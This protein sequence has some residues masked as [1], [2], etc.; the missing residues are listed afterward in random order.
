MQY[1]PKL[2]K[3][4]AQIKTILDE[5]DIAGSVVLHTPGFAE[6]LIKVDPTYA[7]TKVEGDMVR[8]KA[9]LVDFNGDKEAWSKKITD[10]VNMLEC[11]AESNGRNALNIYSVLDELNKKLDIESGTSSHTSHT[12]QNN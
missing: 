4:M 2:K 7:C 6:Y 12:T 5:N 10:T 1:S 9:K 3:A 8:I 11:L